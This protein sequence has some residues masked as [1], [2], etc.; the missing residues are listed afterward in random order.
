VLLFFKAQQPRRRDWRDFVAFMPQLSANQ[1][2][3]LRDA[4]ARVD[5][6]HPWIAALDWAAMRR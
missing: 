4:I 5:A 3:W 2:T 1:N 6:Q